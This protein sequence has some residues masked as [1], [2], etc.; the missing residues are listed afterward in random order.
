MIL[1]IGSPSWTSMMRRYLSDRT[2]HAASPY[3]TDNPNAN[4]TGLPR[5]ATGVEHLRAASEHIEVV[6]DN[7]WQD[8]SNA[9]RFEQGRAIELAQHLNARRLQETYDKGWKDGFNS[10]PK[11]DLQTISINNLDKPSTGS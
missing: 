9:N 2:S 6:I 4:P 5:I 1:L 3:P 7:H 8:E 11:Q 10:H